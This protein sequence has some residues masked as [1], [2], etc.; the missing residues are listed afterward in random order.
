MTDTATKTT[1]RPGV[2]VTSL[3]GNV[4]PARTEAD[5]EK[6]STGYSLPSALHE[7]LR[8]AAKERGVSASYLVQKAVEDY[9][10]RLIPVDELTLVRPVAQ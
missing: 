4:P 8:T 1:V 3:N 5:P 2:S 6:V 7:E 10:P 9:L